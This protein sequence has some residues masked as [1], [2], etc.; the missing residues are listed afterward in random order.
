MPV[1][2]AARGPPIR[3]RFPARHLKRL[4]EV[5]QRAPM[6]PRF[7]DEGADGV[8]GNELT[9]ADVGRM[10]AALGLCLRRNLDAVW[11][12]AVIGGDGRPIGAPLVAAAG[13]GLRWAGCNLID[14]GPA[15]AACLMSAIEQLDA[16]GG[17]LVGNPSGQPQR[18]GLKFFAPGP[19][20]ISRGPWLDAIERISQAHADRPARRYGSLRRV[21]A[22]AA[23]LATLSPYYHALRPLRL[24]LDARCPPVLEYLRKL[25]AAVA[26]NISTAAGTGPRVGEQ[27]RAQRAHFGFRIGDDGETCRLWDEQGRPVPPEALLLLLARHLL[28]DRASPEGHCDGAVIVEEGTSP[29]LAAK[30]AA[31]GGRPVG[32]AAT[33]AVMAA[34]ICE[35]HAVLGGGPSGRYWHAVGRLALPDALRT[36]TLLLVLLSRDDRPVSEVL[37]AAAAAG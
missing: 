3:A 6:R 18:A 25:T 28:A 29:T 20:P 27:V 36:L 32:S 2:V 15:S 17:I 31:A 4:R 33:R 13:E 19:C 21:Q 30:I 5:A 1:A 11:P 24:V 10:A 16:S 8:Q 37:D 14:I 9:Q 34:A 26:V 12:L 35:Q 7:H 22:E 23:Y